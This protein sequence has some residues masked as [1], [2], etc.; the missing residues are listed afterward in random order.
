MRYVGE[1]L[2]PTAARWNFGRAI[3]RD[4]HVSA[5]FFRPTQTDGD[6]ELWVS[7][8]L[9]DSDT[10]VFQHTEIPEPLRP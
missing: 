9:D 10:W 1:L 8:K 4:R 7:A 2:G 3:A 5:M 6:F